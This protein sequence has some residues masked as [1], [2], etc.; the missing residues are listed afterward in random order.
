M[1]VRFRAGVR[2]TAELVDLQG[3]LG[4]PAKVV[5]APAKEP[6]DIANFGQVRGLPQALAGLLGALAAATMGYLLVSSVRRRR[7]DLAVF[8][9]L[10]LG[11]RQVSA[12]IAWHATTV[13]ATAVLFGLPIGLGAGRWMWI[14]VA[15][16][17][18][19][20]PRPVVPA[21][22]VILLVP[23]AILL[24]NL[25][26]AVPARAAGRVHAASVLRSE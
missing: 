12:V 17:L 24:A 14:Y 18:G 22:L 21:T 10:G 9:V 15:D 20:V 7:D 6:T 2:K 26:A 11:T 5:V 25:I 4:G 23:T 1:F 16:Q 3:R 19:V 13:A 8:K